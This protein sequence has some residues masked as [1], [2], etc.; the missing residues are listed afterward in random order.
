[1]PVFCLEL[2]WVAQPSTTD[3]SMLGKS[4]EELEADHPIALCEK[5]LEEHVVRVEFP[6][7]TIDNFESRLLDEI[8]CQ[9]AVLCVVADAVGKPH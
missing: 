4:L 2:R 7:A 5:G 3:L 1:M 6:V 8:S 9:G